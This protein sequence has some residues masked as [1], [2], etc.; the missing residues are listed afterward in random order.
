MLDGISRAATA[1]SSGAE[2]E[3]PPSCDRCRDAGFL[4]AD[5]AVGHPDFGKIV[6]CGCRAEQIK[7]QRSDRLRG[8]SNLGPLSR[9]T[10]EGFRP[11]GLRQE[12]GR[13]TRIRAVLEQAQ[14]FAAEP[15]GW[16]V[17]VGPPGCGKTHLAAAIANQRLNDG[18]AVIFSI[19][20][21]LLDHLRLTFNPQSDV[22]YDELFETVKNTE[23]LILD[24]LGTQSSTPWAQEKLFQLLNHRYHAQ[25]PTVVTTNHRLDEL[26]ER[27]RARLTDPQLASVYLIEDWDPGLLQQ[28]GGMSLE[29]LR[30]MSFETF[31]VRGMEEAPNE[32][33]RLA[34]GLAR[35]FAEDPSGWLLLTGLPGTGKTHLAAAIANVLQAGGVSVCLVTVPDL[36][37]YLRT[38]FAPDSRVRYERVFDAV[39]TAPVL[40][41]DDLGS[42]SG[43]P[44][45]QEKL[46]QLFNYRYNAKLPTVI[47]SNLTLDDHDARLRSRMLDPTLCTLHVLQTTPYRMETGSGRGGGPEKGRGRRR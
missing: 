7:R 45:A 28:L 41:L 26:D 40:I 24:D 46:F 5:V 42:H 10:F 36:L 34:L 3:V 23:L 29:R 32:S 37:D 38:A 11:D 25:L 1:A 2:P 39:R 44:W 27:L 12:P 20:P 16:L 30:S 35:G 21:D 9:L 19:V 47:T 33:L 31:N 4:R 15:E 14:R 6:P 18:R 43:T 8:L 13:R 17:L 22:T